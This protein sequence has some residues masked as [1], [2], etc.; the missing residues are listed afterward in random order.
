MLPE[1]KTL[2]SVNLKDWLSE[3]ELSAIRSRTNYHGF[4]MIG[5]DWMIIAAVFVLVGSYPNPLTIIAGV[6]VLGARQLGF[7]VLVH[8]CGHHILFKNPA[9]NRFCGNWLAGYAI[10][11]NMQA[12]ARGHLKHHQLAG[13]H[14]DPDLP[15]YQDYPIPRSRFRRKVL[16]DLTGQVGYRRIKSIVKAFASF[17]RLDSSN[18]QYLLRSLG[19]NLL[20]LTILMLFDA[21]WLYLLWLAAF[22]TTHMLVSRIRQIGEHGAVPDLYSPDPRK[23]TRTVLASPLE[24]LLI[25]PHGVSYHLEHHLNASVPIYRLEKLHKLLKKKGFYDNTH[26]PK[27]Y[28]QMLKEVTLAG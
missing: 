12:Y 19:V 11:S 14:Q 15:N 6:F 10:F 28:G 23:N 18:R 26:F 24:R 2:Q 9:L 20:L 1:E 7:G 27:G 5:F 3:T 25:A 8:E 21:A 22:M 17:S 4:L 16:R 13:T